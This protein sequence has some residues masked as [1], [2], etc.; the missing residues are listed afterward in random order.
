MGVST[1]LNPEINKTSLDKVVY[2]QFDEKATPDQADALDSVF[3]KQDSTELGAISVAEFMPAGLFEEIAEEADYEMDEFKAGAK[4][5]YDILAYKKE[6]P[7]PEEFYEDNQHNFV[8]NGIRDAGRK[9]RMSRDKFAFYRSYQDAFSTT[10]ITT[11]DDAALCSDSH[12]GLD[13]STI[14]N[15]ET[16]ALSPANLDTAVKSLELQ[17]DQR[18]D[19]G[20]HSFAGLL[21]P[22]T[23]YKSAFEIVDSIQMAHTA[24]NQLNI[25]NTKYGTIRMACS[26]WL[27]ST[28]NPY[29]SSYANSS[30]FLV[31][32]FH[33]IT[34]YQRLP[35]ATKMV[36]PDTDRK[37]RWFYRMR[38]RE[39]VV[40]ETWEGI[41]GADGSA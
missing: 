6:F 22:R 15:K 23:L 24:E 35:L 31:S 18:G 37:G 16:G 19:L 34:R 27:D 33:A 29:N 8:P 5:T 3:F 4:T 41:V 38:F 26:P 40:A 1:G 9:A 14:D 36:P 17:K 7:I 11:P 2:T 25:F 12:V 13:G 39:R 32:G 28:Y 30:Y 20:G 21:V 10:T